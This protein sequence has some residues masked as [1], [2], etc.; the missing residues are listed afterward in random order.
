M[1]FS[2]MEFD[3]ILRCSKNEDL[4]PMTNVRMYTSLI[5]NWGVAAKHNFPGAARRAHDLLRRMEVESG[6]DTGIDPKLGE[7]V[8]CDKSLQ[9]DSGTYENVVGVC[10]NVA[11]PEEHD[12]AIEIAFETY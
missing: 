6:M 5:K 12:E 8:F 1:I 2:K 3:S 11:N 7:S 10:G 9:T 4:A